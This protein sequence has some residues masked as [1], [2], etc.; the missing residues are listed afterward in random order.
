MS[1][2]YA[3]KDLTK[4]KILAAM[5]ELSTAKQICERTGLREATVRSHIEELKDHVLNVTNVYPMLFMAN[6][7]KTFTPK[8]KP[9]QRDLR[10]QRYLASVN[11]E[12]DPLPVATKK[13][14]SSLGGYDYY[15]PVISRTV[16]E[17]HPKAPVGKRTPHI[18]SGS[19]AH[20]HFAGD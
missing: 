18:G 11:R 2:E 3:Q 20:M 7:A 13:V 6:P 1:E 19:Y 8:P 16:D 14:L 17:R 15:I 5:T 9:S 4:I 12:P 10:R